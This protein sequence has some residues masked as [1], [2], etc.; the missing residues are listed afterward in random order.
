MLKIRKGKPPFVTVKLGQDAWMRVRA[1][2]STDVDVA[3]AKVQP[4]VMGMLAGSDALPALGLALGDDFNVEALKDPARLGA[5]VTRLTEVYLLLACQDG[6]TGIVD[7]DGTAIEKPCELSVAGL[8]S[9]P[10]L[11]HRIMAVVNAA[12]HAEEAEKNGSAASPP[13]GAGTPTGAPPAAGTATPAPSAALSTATS[14]TAAAAR[15]SSLRP[16]HGQD[17]RLLN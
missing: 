13:G 9:D 4:L 14:A 16:L 8:L 1:A 7:E 17:G 12:V 3:S 11:R 6:W 5:A 15:R 10:T 2:T